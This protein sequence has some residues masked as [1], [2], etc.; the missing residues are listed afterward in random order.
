MRLRETVSG[1][2]GTEDPDGST[3][4]TVSNEYSSASVRLS[5]K[6]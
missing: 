5:V 2:T 3:E 6:L 1:M 4:V